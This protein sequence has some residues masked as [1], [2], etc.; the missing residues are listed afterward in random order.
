LNFYCITIK[1]CTVAAK[2]NKQKQCIFL[3]K[4]WH[5]RKIVTIILLTFFIAST[6]CTAQSIDSISDLKETLKLPA[7]YYSKVDKKLSSINNQLTK[8][9]LKY[10]A[11][12]QRQEQRIQ[13]KLLKI[14]GKVIADNSSASYLELYQR[15]S[16]NSPD[17]SNALITGEYNPNLDSL[18]TSLS[19]LKQFNGISDKVKA[20]LK[21]FNQLQ[22]NLQQS[23]NIKAF[24][25]ER[26]NQIKEMLSKYTN[27]PGSLKN[28]FTKLN[29]TAYYYSAQVKEYKD[30]LKQPDKMEQKA[31]SILRDVPAFQKFMKENSQLGNLFGIPLNYG[32]SQSLAGLQTLDQVQQLVRSRIGSEPN[33]GQLL[34]QQVQAA[35]G[36]LNIFKDK[37]NKLGGG[38]GDIAMP[39]FKPNDQKTK[40]FF[41]RLEYGSNLQ[42]TRGNY[43]F[44][45]TTDLG[46]SIGY[47]LSSKGTVGIGASYK[48]GWGKDIQH[49]HI[50]A[51][52]M[53][54]R[55]FFEYKLKKTFYASG[56]FEYN[57]Q[58]T[59]NS[60]QQLEK[61]DGWQQSGLIGISKVVDVKSKL[62]KK[63]K[64]Q[65]L[66]DF[67]SYEQIPHVTPHIIFRVGYI[68]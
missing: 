37:L 9:S 29:K 64:L 43:G 53:G 67:L 13:Q 41:K 24:I 22:N 2:E 34:Q 4:N 31:L 51:E 33:A 12:F 49:I 20:P 54:L 25:A 66:W 26:K 55:S 10:L 52:G 16:S 47:K 19:Y 11:K 1:E 28:E 18:G 7:K 57:Y 36:Q 23:E 59:I 62:F 61:S 38:S 39:D 27:L 56:G 5:L 32:N 15:I 17:S 45:T 44:P 46:L 68:F 63:T 3:L 65:L 35:Q 50:S 58:Q 42:T 14:D 6:T 48:S 60:F 8:K 21:S 40:P 30:L